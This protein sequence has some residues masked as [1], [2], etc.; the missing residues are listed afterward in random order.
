M[1]PYIYY[2]SVCVCGISIESYHEYHILFQFLE[3]LEKPSLDT[4][5]SMCLN[6]CFRFLSGVYWVKHLVLLQ[7]LIE[8]KL[9]WISGSLNLTVNLHNPIKMSCISITTSRICITMNCIYIILV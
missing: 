7:I 4:W 6:D 9:I 8:N 3:S 2:V 5:K 1:Y